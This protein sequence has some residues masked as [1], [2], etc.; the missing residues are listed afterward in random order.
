[1]TGV[2]T[3]ALPI[4]LIWSRAEY[5][6]PV[7][8][9]ENARHSPSTAPRGTVVIAASSMAT[10]ASAIPKRVAKAGHRIENSLFLLMTSAQYT[11]WSPLV[12]IG[13]D[14]RTRNPTAPPQA[15]CA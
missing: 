2:Q 7:L 5:L 1:M 15:G 11:R 9:P 8:L 13:T 10:S 12:A 14:T 4:L 3:C 6:D